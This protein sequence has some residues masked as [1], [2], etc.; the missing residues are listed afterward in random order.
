MS[1]TDFGSIVS[2]EILDEVYATREELARK[3][4]YDVGKLVD[5]LA[6]RRKELEKQGVRFVSKEDLEKR[7]K[8]NE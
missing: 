4:D 3:C 5:Y 2:N 7:N 6:E 1:K 8:G